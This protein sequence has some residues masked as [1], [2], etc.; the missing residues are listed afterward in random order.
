[1]KTSI[2]S[3][4]RLRWKLTLS[5]TLVTVAA[6][7][8][9][10]LVLLVAL[11]A[12]VQ[13]GA[14]PALLAD[15]MRQEYAPTLAPHL[16]EDP[17]DK[18]AIDN[19]LEDM[20]SQSGLEAVRPPSGGLRADSDWN[21]SPFEGY[22]FVVDE[23]R[24]FISS[25]P[26]L[27]EAEG[28]RFETAPSPGLRP[29]VTAALNGEEGLG[30][31]SANA[32]NNQLAMAVPVRGEDGRVVGALGGIMQLPNLTGPLIGIIAGSAAALIIPAAILGTIFG[33][34]TAWGITRRIQRL[35]QAA[36]SWSR[37]DFSTEVKDRS[38]D[39]LGQLT[40]ELNSMAGQLENLIQARG[41]L[42]TLEARNRFA[43]DL[44]DSVKQ[45]I[46]A[47]S[48]QIAAARAFVNK[49]PE[50]AEEHLAQAHELVR[51]AQKELNVLIHEMRPAALGDKGLAK[52]LR[53]YAAKWSEGSEI[54][55]EVHVRGEREVPLETEQTAFRIV[56]E[57]LANV[58]KHSEAQSVELDLVYTPDNLTL[59]VTDDGHGFD[60]A[61]N[62]G[63][64]FGLQSMRERSVRRGGYINVESA[65]GKGTRIT[66]VV[67][68]D[69]TP[70]EK[71][72]K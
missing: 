4:R 41:E 37:G 61:Q 14:L 38:K 71:G 60:P 53:E 68:L 72:G 52:A 62:P 44:H 48:M 35:G 27:E 69:G 28:R 47:T 63:E 5:Y 10:E 54:P 26:E 3:L 30:D 15:Q 55:S 23:D 19:S 36:Q 67:P 43:R 17:P 7:V 64:G 9:L 49:S 51:Q 40:R 50:E 20:A 13:S 29:L 45:Q 42:A 32:P 11:V 65:P 24:R 21:F 39:E 16:A 1:V 58:A 22:I 8:L 25:V 70:P 33:F 46:F 59:R 57:A 66:C 31:L 56:Q 2:F 34:L 18:Q 12:F 6:V